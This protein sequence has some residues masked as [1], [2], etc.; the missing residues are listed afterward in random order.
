MTRTIR[1]LV[2]NKQLLIVQK[3]QNHKPK[4][5]THSEAKSKQKNIELT[6]LSKFALLRHILWV[7]S[8]KC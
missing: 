1:F 6:N 2:V 3:V 7:F 4:K 8:L 5:K